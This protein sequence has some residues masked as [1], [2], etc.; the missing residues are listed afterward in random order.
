MKLHDSKMFFKTLLI[1]SIAFIYMFIKAINTGLIVYF[2]GCVVDVILMAKGLYIFFDEETYAKSK[3]KS[4]RYKEQL[5]QSFGKY[6]TLAPYGSFGFMVL[7]LAFS[8]ILPNQ[9]WI[10]TLFIVLAGAYAVW[11]SWY[12]KKPKG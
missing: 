11:F 9:V 7:A 1:G 5:Q 2:N 6:A 12:C 3:A 4:V 10:S 8:Y